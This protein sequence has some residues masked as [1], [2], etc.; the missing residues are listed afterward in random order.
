MLQAALCHDSHVYSALPSFFSMQRMEKDCK[1]IFQWIR[2]G[3]YSKDTCY[4]KPLRTIANVVQECSNTRGQCLPPALHRN[5]QK[6]TVHIY[7]I[8][9]CK[10]VA[11]CTA[12]FLHYGSAQNIMTTVDDTSVVVAKWFKR[13]IFLYNSAHIGTVIAPVEYPACAILAT[14]PQN[15]THN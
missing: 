13:P 15:S 4:I 8:L 12:T 10:L 6:N 9:S 1:A 7:C 11:Q 3:A 5:L 14:A 2:N